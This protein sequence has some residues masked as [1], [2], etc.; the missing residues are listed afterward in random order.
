MFYK[1][2]LLS[3]I[4]GLSPFAFSE[5]GP[6][7]LAAT[8]YPPYTIIQQFGTVGGVDAE[9]VKAA[10]SQQSLQISVSTP[11]WV[12][13]LKS[14]EHGKVDGLLSCTKNQQRSQFLYYSSPINQ[15][16]RGLI[17]KASHPQQD[18]RTLQQ[19]SHLKIIAIR[20]WSTQTELESKGI[21]H[22]QVDTIPQAL[23][24][25]LMRDFDAIYSGIESIEYYAK[26][27]DMGDKIRS[28]TLVSQPPK[29]LY[30]CLGK[31]TPNALTILKQFNAGLV[32]IKKNGQ[33]DAILN[34]YKL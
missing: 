29:N 25:L 21:K 30:L 8:N 18:I 11:P 31:K 28:H 27:A 23:D 33:L 10:F 7:S 16:T 22:T 32:T 5:P 2:A 15:I 17:L 13:A 3:M 12:R 24:M 19:A 6:I 1:I 14:V 4:L 9:I 26:Q 34:K 20:K